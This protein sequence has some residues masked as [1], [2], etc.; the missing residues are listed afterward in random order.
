MNNT[1]DVSPILR[2]RVKL[3]IETEIKQIICALNGQC[4]CNDHVRG[5]LENVTNKIMQAVGLGKVFPDI[6]GEYEEMNAAI[7][8][9]NEVLNK[10]LMI[11]PQLQQEKKTNIK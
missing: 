2:N 6:E 10:N 4:I 3:L 5:L 8:A 11:T 1:P 9:T 7:K